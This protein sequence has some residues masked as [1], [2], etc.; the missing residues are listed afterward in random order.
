MNRCS[1]CALL[2]F[3]TCSV[4]ANARLAHG[5]AI[6]GRDFSIALG[7]TTEEAPN[8]V[9]GPVTWNDR[10]TYATNTDTSLTPFA[11]SPTVTG[12][13][14]SGRGPGFQDR[15]LT[16]GRLELGNIDNKVGFLGGDFQV[17]IEAS[18]DGSAPGNVNRDN[19]NYRLEVVIESIS[20]YAGAFDGTSAGQPPWTETPTLQWIETTPGYEQMSG[21]PTELKLIRDVTTEYQTA[22]NYTRVEANPLDYRA[23]VASPHESFTR[24]FSLVP[25][26]M[27]MDQDGDGPENWTLGDGFEVT[28]RVRLYYNALGEHPTC[29]LDGDGNCNIDDID[30]LVGEV[31]AGTDNGGLDMTGDGRVDQ[32]D[33]AQWREIAASQNGL[34][35]PYL[36]GDANLDGIVDARDLNS[37]GLSWR[38]S[39]NTWS[40]GDFRAVGTVNAQNL[41]ALAVN[42]GNSVPMAAQAVPE[43][44][45]LAGLLAAGVC[46]LLWRQFRNDHAQ[47]RLCHRCTPGRH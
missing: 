19:P 36:E 13:L 24:T 41:N 37:I 39:P 27:L 32:Q 29:D 26:E 47:I 11:F 15:V 46:L 21:S 22:A 10:E 8:Q 5:A 44:A 25:S 2:L 35:A 1:Y 17:A 23:P 3:I 33:L 6:T 16:D 45:G 20:L 7:F 14:F 28:G 4:L 42:W 30:R 38:E 12:A 31:I 9:N 18:F 40:Q 34:A 43:P